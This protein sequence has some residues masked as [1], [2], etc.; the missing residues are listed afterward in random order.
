MKLLYCSY[1]KDIVK[2]IST[3]RFCLCKRCYGKYL[4]DGKTVVVHGSGIVI[5]IDNNS[6]YAEIEKYIHDPK[7]NIDRSFISFIISISSEFIK[8]LKNE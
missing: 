7:S 4:G 1:C 5:G 3:D 6:F 2:L 8:I